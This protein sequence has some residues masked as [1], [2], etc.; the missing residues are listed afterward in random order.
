[1]YFTEQALQVP[2]LPLPKVIN[3]LRVTRQELVRLARTQTF[4]EGVSF[5]KSHARGLGI[6]GAFIV[7]QVCRDKTRTIVRRLHSLDGAVHTGGIRVLTEHGAEAYQ[8][9]D[10]LEEE[11][12]EEQWKVAC[13]DMAQQMIQNSMEY[14]KMH[15]IRS[16]SD[17][18]ARLQRCADV[19]RVY[20][21]LPATPSIGNAA[22]PGPSA[23]TES[24]AEHQDVRLYEGLQ[25]ALGQPAM[26]EDIWGAWCMELRRFLWAKESG[27][28]IAA[29]GYLKQPA[30]PQSQPQEAFEQTQQHLDQEH[31]CSGSRQGLRQEPEGCMHAHLQQQ[32]KRQSKLAPSIPLEANH[33]Q[34][35]VPAEVLPGCKLP[36]ILPANQGQPQVKLEDDTAGAFEQSWTHDQS[37]RGETKDVMA[38]SEGPTGPTDTVCVDELRDIP[39]GAPAAAAPASD[40]GTP[41]QVCDVDDKPEREGP[42]LWQGNLEQQECKEGAAFPLTTGT[43]PPD[44]Q[45]GQRQGRSAF[46]SLPSPRQQQVPLA[47]S[48]RRQQDNADDAKGLSQRATAQPL[49]RTQQSSRSDSRSLSEL[50]GHPKRKSRSR[51]RSCSASRERHGDVRGSRSRSRSR[52]RS[53]S[54]QFRPARGGRGKGPAVRGGRKLALEG[55]SRCWMPPHG[56]WNKEE[57]AWEV[58][59]FLRCQPGWSAGVPML[60]RAG[61]AVPNHILRTSGRRPASFL[62]GFPH[63]WTVT[64]DTYMVLTARPEHATTAGPAPPASDGSTVG[65]ISCGSKRS[66]EGPDGAEGGQRVLWSQGVQM[67]A[68][69]V[70]RITDYLRGVPQG[71]KFSKL[72]SHGFNIPYTILGGRTVR[73]WAQEYSHL[74]TVTNAF[75]KLRT[76]RDEPAR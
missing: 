52:S 16:I 58:H 11:P 57:W 35:Q 22:G 9:E 25:Y 39:G 73:A 44:R 34:T 51:S 4:L 30:P 66:L 55:D 53:P 76:N 65:R 18:L 21:S 48:P 56:S 20:N 19:L 62:H 1:M 41:G 60:L 47:P 33:A 17:R 68:A 7:L 43:A 14:I 8:L 38:T 72:R 49:P 67:E 23:A 46:Q 74:W 28:L 45:Q 12:S 54:P 27:Q 70:S 63:L 10:V 40:P 37:Q 13:A 5:L 26:Q 36:P 61:L 71:I 24:Q 59:R 6:S 32:P 15:E 75:I 64:G 3:V 69:L 50:Q 42:Q 29:H 31:N 2:L